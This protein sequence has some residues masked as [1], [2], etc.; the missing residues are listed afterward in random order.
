M[1]YAQYPLMSYVPSVGGSLYR[2]SPA[3]STKLESELKQHLDGRD[4]AWTFE[5]RRGDPA[6]EIIA[7]A[8]ER[9]AS[10]IVVGHRGHN[11]ALNLLIGSVATR[12][13]HQAPQPVLVAR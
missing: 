8:N 1:N 10:V 13:V 9:D 2:P 12:L 4:V 11:P 7:A 5:I 3:R 6:N